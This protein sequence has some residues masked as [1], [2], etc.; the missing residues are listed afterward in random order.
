MFCNRLTLGRGRCHP[1]P[2]A[3]SDSCQS[4]SRSPQSPDCCV[5]TSCSKVKMMQN[6]GFF[7][8]GI[9]TD[10]RDW[11]SYIQYFTETE[12]PKDQKCVRKISLCKVAVSNK[13]EIAFFRRRNEWQAN[14]LHYICAMKEIHILHYL[15]T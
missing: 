3:A 11:L 5:A 9:V 13:H 7:V 10:I 2:P 6:I 4:R 1:S 14:T 12:F 15:L 8:T